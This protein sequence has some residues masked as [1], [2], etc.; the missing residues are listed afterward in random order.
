MTATTADIT[1][2]RWSRWRTPVLAWA[3]SR[4]LVIVL[5]I[6]VERLLGPTSLGNDP[7]VPAPL[8]LLGSWDTS[9][10]IDIARHGYDH[11]TGLV[12]VVFTNLAFFPLLPMVMWVGIRTSTNP[13]IWGFVVSNLAFFGAVLGMH[14]LSW[15]RRDLAFANRATWVFAFAPPAIYASLAYTDGLLIALAIGASLAATRGHWYLAGLAAA[16]AALTRPPGILVAVLV[17]MIAASAADLPWPARVR[18]ALIGSVPAVLTVGGFLAWMQLERGSWELP[19]NAQGAWHRGALG[20]SLV[21]GLP[22]ATYSVIDYI[23]PPFKHGLF[24]HLVWTG[25]ER[26]FLFTIL[27]VVLCVAL[28]RTEGGWRSPWVLFSVLAIFVPLLS[29]SYSS[30]MRFG[31]VAFPLVWPVADW[32]GHGGRRRQTWVIGATLFVTVVLVLQLQVTSP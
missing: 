6:I 10:Y 30:M 11:Y 31:L 4:A 14:R 23:V 9:W 27:M 8:T 32:L 7:S 15:D 26:D 20:I 12:G 1:D 25:S 5:A 21:T 16:L 22:K 2:S 24:Q 18:H 29:G 28:W 3:L 13:F 17:V 19:L